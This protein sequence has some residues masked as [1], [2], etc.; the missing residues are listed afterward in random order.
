MNFNFN[1][2]FFFLDYPWTL[3]L[4]NSVYFIIYTTTVLLLRRMRQL[5]IF[6][7]FADRLVL[8]IYRC[9]VVFAQSVL[10][11]RLVIQ[12]IFYTH[13]RIKKP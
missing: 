2:Q 9:I 1:Y 8:T 3:C 5:I 13:S 12:C 7:G 6:L 11:L 4:S 10:Y